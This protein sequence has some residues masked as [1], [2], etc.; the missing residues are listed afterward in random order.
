MAKPKSEQLHKKE[1]LT[2][3]LAAIIGKSPQWVR[4]LTRDSVLEQVG[5]G[6][7]LL[8]ES[9]QAYIKHIEGETSDG[10]VSYRDEK[11]EHERIKKE[12]AQLEL[13]EKRRNLHTTADVQ[14]AWGTLLVNFRERMT[15][16]PPRIANKLTYMTDE[17]EIRQYLEDQLN[18]MLRLLARYD[19]LAGDDS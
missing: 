7:F 11:A 2:S 14:E 10:K 4:Q 3:E 6:K 9:V 16:L 19:P 5:R 8:G 17:K 18:E 12:I 1:V 13:E 15:G